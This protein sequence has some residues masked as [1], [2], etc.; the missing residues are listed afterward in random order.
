MADSTSPRGSVRHVIVTAEGADR[1]LDNF[2][3]SVLGDVPKT[4]IYRIIRTGE[5]RVNGGRCKPA[6]KLLLGDTVRVPPVRTEPASA[7]GVPSR[8][9]EEFEA[10]I[11]FEDAQV[12]VVNKSAGLAVHAGSGVAYGVIDI[13]RAA[14]PQAARLDLVH[15]LDRPTSGCLLLAKD[16]PALRTLNAQLAAHQLRK[17]YLALVAGPVARRHITSDAPLDVHHRRDA[18]RHTIATETGRAAT[19]RFRLIR[20]FADCSLV[21]AEPETGRTHQIRVHAANLGHPLAGDEKYGRAEFNQALARLGLRRLFLH[22]A[23]LE[24]RL[25]HKHRIEAPLPADLQAVLD[26]LKAMRPES[27]T[28]YT[29]E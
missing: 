16:M 29:D 19:T 13:A 8:Q 14:R 28:G 23:A 25:T 26:T 18:E 11:L 12:I 24:F 3:G 17:I 22:A 2:L 5:V 4:L 21:E 10:S 6:Q 9:V 15:R 7:A 20:R 1:R 27:Q